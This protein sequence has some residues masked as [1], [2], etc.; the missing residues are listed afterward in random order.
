MR[1]FDRADKLDFAAN[2]NPRQELRRGFIPWY[3]KAAKLKR[4]VRILFGHWS[5][6]PVGC[7]G[8]SFALDGGCVWGGHLVALRIDFDAE[9]WFFVDSHTKK[10]L[11]KS[12][13]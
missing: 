12:K 5:T 9:E 11:K 2:G 13:K 3:A 8:R 4:S 10:S 7:Y 1:Y 6:L